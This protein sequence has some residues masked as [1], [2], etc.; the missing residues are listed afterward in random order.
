M[1]NIYC[2]ED[3]ECKLEPMASTNQSGG[4]GTTGLIPGKEDYVIPLVARGVKK[5]AQKQVGKGRRQVGK[6]KRVQKGKGRAKKRDQRLFEGGE[7][8]Q[9]H[10]NS[11]ND[12]LH[13]FLPV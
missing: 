10:L 5:M 11:T 4:G 7:R 6:G 2:S 1:R 13:S 9:H 3:R 8:K 12:W